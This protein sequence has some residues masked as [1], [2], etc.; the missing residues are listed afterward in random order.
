LVNWLV[1]REQSATEVPKP[2][3]E[4]LHCNI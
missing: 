4:G 3:P 2:R 1:S